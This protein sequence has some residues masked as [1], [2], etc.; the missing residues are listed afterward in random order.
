MSE[1]TE[2]DMPIYPSILESPNV[3]NRCHTNCA[4]IPNFDYVIKQ[5]TMKANPADI[6]KPYIEIRPPPS[7]QAKN[8]ITFKNINF[9]LDKMLLFYTPLHSVP[10]IGNVEGE[11]HLEFIS[12]SS[13][14]SY[15]KRIVL[16]V[17]CVQGEDNQVVSDFLGNV[18]SNLNGNQEVELQVNYSGG[19]NLDSMIPKSNYYFYKPNSMKEQY[20]RVGSSRRDP[21]SLPSR[22]TSGDDKFYM[23]VYDKPISLNDTVIQ[24]L[25]KNRKIKVIPND[26]SSFRGKIYYYNRN[27]ASGSSGFGSGDGNRLIPLGNGYQMNCQYNEDQVDTTEN[28][29]GEGEDEDEEYENISLFNRITVLVSIVPV[30]MIVLIILVQTSGIIPNNLLSLGVGMKLLVFILF[31]LFVAIMVLLFMKLYTIALIVGV[32]ILG[33]FLIYM[34]YQTFKI[35][36]LINKIG[37]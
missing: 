2:N 9:Q 13:V 1:L 33:V 37:S 17:L 23:L 4:I 32:V 34:T 6:E 22:K 14:A 10:N 20:R 21:T 12:Q 29:N 30:T 35:G 11:I 16:S 19:F 25:R 36:D 7:E 28:D 18:T 3:Y 27:T 8:T 31:G 15:A 5:V 24:V 26:N